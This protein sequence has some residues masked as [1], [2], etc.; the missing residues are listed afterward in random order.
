MADVTEESAA[1]EFPS[2]AA[3][4]AQLAEQSP[5]LE[6]LVFVRIDGTTSSYRWAELYWRSS[7]IASWLRRARRRPRRPG[8]PA[9]RNSPELMLSA[10]A[11]WKVGAVP[12]PVRWDLPDWELDAG[13]RGGRR[14]GAPRHGD[15]AGSRPRA[16]R[17]MAPLPEWCRPDPRHLQQRVDGTPKVIVIDQPGAVGRRSGRSRSPAGGSTSPARRSSSCRRRSTTPTGSPR[18][19]ACSPATGSCCSR[20]S[21]RRGSST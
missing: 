19:R 7:E 10:L 9:P 2:Y 11:A 20:S 18:C 21:M 1:S 16:G 14:Q 17:P 6:A 12:V 8:G 15:V 5:D 4:I 13:A 3:R